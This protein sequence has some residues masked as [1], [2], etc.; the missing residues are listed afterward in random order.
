MYSIR[1]SLFEQRYKK[2]EASMDSL[3]V[4]GNTSNEILKTLNQTKII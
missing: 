1:H 2:I 4:T 3:C